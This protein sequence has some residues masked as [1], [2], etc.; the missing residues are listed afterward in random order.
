[1]GKIN[2][3]NYEEFFLDFVE[4]SMSEAEIKDLNYFLSKNPNLKIELKNFKNIILQPKQIEFKAKTELIKQTN[5]KFFNITN[6]EYL[7]IAELEND[8][9]E[10]EKIELNK[11]VNSQTN[12]KK[13]LK[14]YKSIKL[15][16]N[17]EVIYPFK[18]NLLRKTVAFYIKISSSVA[19]AVLIMFFLTNQ[20]IF[21]KT[22]SG[23]VQLAMVKRNLKVDDVKK[24]KKE[25]INNQL[26]NKK[27]KQK[28]L[29]SHKQ[30]IKLTNNKVFAFDD[31]ESQKEIDIYKKLNVSIPKL[32]T[33]TLIFEKKNSEIEELKKDIVF[34]KKT[35]QNKDKLWQ[36]A[37]T[38]VKIWKVVSSSDFEMNNSY[39]KNGHI[40]KLNLYASNFKF[41]KTFN[42]Q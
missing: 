16:Q 10:N 29:T 8:I 18:N 30:T 2:I 40:E 35:I 24:I 31:N 36:Y 33:E 13:D 39:K 19:A 15:L 3:H 6:F 9:S 41:S 28:F 14:I 7:A 42:K 25:T 20:F 17:K 1:L 22:E 27:N 5:N 23:T 12:L 26:K 34:N 21:L 4:G 32:K 11:I 37:E 38:G